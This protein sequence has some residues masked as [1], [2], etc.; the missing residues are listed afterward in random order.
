MPK[1]DRSQLLESDQPYQSRTAD[2]PPSHGPQSSD[3]LRAVQDQV[4]SVKDVMR[5]NVTV[6][7][8]NMDKASAL[9]GTTS[10]LAA[11]ARQFH[12]SARKTKTHMWWGNFKIKLAAGF[13][14]LLVLL[15]ILWSAGA[16]GGGGGVDGDGG[17]DGGARRVLLLS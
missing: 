8:D 16:F 5:E 9:E 15:L 10:E 13:A 12:T 1:N 11:Q 2:S 6:M 17:G 3:S 14:C 7:L 4:D